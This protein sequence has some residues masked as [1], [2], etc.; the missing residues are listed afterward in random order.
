MLLSYNGTAAGGRGGVRCEAEKSFH[1]ES[2]DDAFYFTYPAS[3]CIGRNS[4]N[5]E[6][7]NKSKHNLQQINPLQKIPPNSDKSATCGLRDNFRGR[8]KGMQRREGYR[9]EDVKYIIDERDGRPWSP[10]GASLE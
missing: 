7:R 9:E 10:I 4:L 3:C 2:C 8:E 6:R 1:Y 5:Q